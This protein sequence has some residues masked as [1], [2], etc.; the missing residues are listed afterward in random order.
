MAVSQARPAVVLYDDAC[1]F[2]VRLA[3]YVRGR[4]RGVR[5]VPV[6]STEGRRMLAEFGR[7]AGEPQ[8]VMLV[9]RDG[10]QQRSE[11]V[12]R[13]VQRMGGVWQIARVLRAVPRA[14]RDRAY[15]FVARRR[16]S[17]VCDGLVC[18][19]GRAVAGSE[20]AAADEAA[21][22]GP[23]EVESADA[24]VDVEDLADEEQPGTPP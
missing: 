23:L 18:V 7:P 24:A 11:A 8:T 21:G 12:L 1:P 22:P 6:N 17:F 2:C 16:R 13:L 9:D 15:E 4:V 20:V 5:L 3:G 10:L 19:S 14:W